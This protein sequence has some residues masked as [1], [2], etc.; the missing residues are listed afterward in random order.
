MLADWSS[1][2]AGFGIVWAALAVY[3]ITIAVRLRRI[4]REP[5]RD[6]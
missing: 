2:W 1:I 4:D 3:V 6:M 5:R